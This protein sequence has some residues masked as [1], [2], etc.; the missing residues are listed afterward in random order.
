MPRYG[1]IG[2]M[3]FPG[4]EPI[5]CSEYKLKTQLNPS[6]CKFGTCSF[7]RKLLPPNFSKSCTLGCCKQCFNKSIHRVDIDEPSHGQWNYDSDTNELIPHWINSDGCKS[8]WSWC[9]F[10]SL[11]LYHPAKASTTCFSQDSALYIGG[12][13]DAYRSRFP[14][15]VVTVVSNYC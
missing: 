7:P 14:T 9:K 13:I 6:S 15:P 3:A 11:I 1:Y 10:I 2:G 5:S 12:D 4:G 8:R